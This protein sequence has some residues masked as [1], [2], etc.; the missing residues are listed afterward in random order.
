MWIKICSVFWSFQKRYLFHIFS[1][2]LFFKYKWN[3]RLGSS[4]N[5]FVC[6]CMCVET[7]WSRKLNR[8]RGVCLCPLWGTFVCLYGRKRE[9]WYLELEW[10]GGSAARVRWAI[11]QQIEL[12]NEYD[13]ERYPLLTQKRSDLSFVSRYL[14]CIELR[15]ISYIHTYVKICCII[16]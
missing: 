6:V 3:G 7:N 8:E 15:K 16:H 11:K 12:S 10:D 14:F 5:Y 1:H 9:G 2:T 4:V 13:K